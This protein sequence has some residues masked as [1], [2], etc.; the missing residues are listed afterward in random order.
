MT[1]DI[2]L[3][4]EISVFEIWSVHCLE[5]TLVCHT[6]FLEL[7]VSRVIAD[8]IATMTQARCLQQIIETA[9]SLHS[10]LTQKLKDLRIT[11]CL[12]KSKVFCCKNFSL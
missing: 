3:Y 6:Y 12:R 9:S 8:D 10:L 1:G 2:K 5:S 7:T 11:I 4:F